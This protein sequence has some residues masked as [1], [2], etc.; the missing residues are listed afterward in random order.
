MLWLIMY[1][2]S[3]VMLV[4]QS[5]FGS[6][7]MH[8]R[9][10]MVLCCVFILVT[11]AHAYESRYTNQ[12][13]FLFCESVVCGRHPSLDRLHQHLKRNRCVSAGILRRG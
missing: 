3:I 8:D 6:P 2:V 5:G 7:G 9:D 12:D 11:V 1:V 13:V 4:Y 10:C